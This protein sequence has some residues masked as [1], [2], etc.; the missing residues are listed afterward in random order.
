MSFHHFVNY[1]TRFHGNKDLQYLYLDHWRPTNLICH[2][3]QI[4]YDYYIDLERPTVSEDSSFVLKALGAPEWLTLSQQNTLGN[5]TKYS[6][7]S[8][9]SASEFERLRAQ[10]TIT[11]MRCLDMN[12]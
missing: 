3:F 11:T 5:E 1:I 8:Q 2:P 7:L 9:L 12:V 4:D 6:F 10:Y